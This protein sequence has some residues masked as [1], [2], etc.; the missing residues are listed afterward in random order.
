[1]AVA[2]I[3]ITGCASLAPQSHLYPENPTPESLVVENFVS[4]YKRVS[5]CTHWV[6]ETYYFETPTHLELGLTTLVSELFVIGNKT[7]SSINT[8]TDVPNWEN[9]F[10]VNIPGEGYWLLT[11]SYNPYSD[12]K[13]YRLTFLM[14]IFYEGIVAVTTPWH[15]NL[16]GQWI[17]KRFITVQLF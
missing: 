2:A 16:Y 5:I 13:N 4:F 8:R 12:K 3:I 17:P 11:Y 6:Y 7:G 1:M 14:K 9:Q 10:G 15:T